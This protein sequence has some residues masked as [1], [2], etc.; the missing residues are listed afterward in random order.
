MELGCCLALLFACNDA[1][2]HDRTELG[3]AIEADKSLD[4]ALKQ[5]D[6]ASHAGNDVE[7]A[8]ILKRMAAPAAD[9]ALAK[10]NAIDARTAKLLKSTAGMPGLVILRV[11]RGTNDTVIQVSQA[12]SPADRFTYHI[13]LQLELPR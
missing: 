6:D 8:D 3:R 5:A 12:I 4:R 11:Y 10:A 7:A 9:E 1:T 2:A 13:D